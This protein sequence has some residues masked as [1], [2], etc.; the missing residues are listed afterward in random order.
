[1]EELYQAL[2]IQKKVYGFGQQF[3]EKLKP[4]F[5]ELDKTAEY[6]QIKVIKAMQAHRVSA[7]CCSS[8]PSWYRKPA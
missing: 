1:M 2:G 7:E 4:R 6:N 5:A 8:Y 3:E